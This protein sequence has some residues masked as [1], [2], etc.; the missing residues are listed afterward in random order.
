[1]LSNIYF[2]LCSSLRTD[3]KVLYVNLFLTL[4]CVSVYYVVMINRLF[5]R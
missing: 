5:L 1:M 2:N 3:T 4:H